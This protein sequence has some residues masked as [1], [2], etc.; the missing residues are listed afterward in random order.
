MVRKGEGYKSRLHIGQEPCLSNQL[1]MQGKWN[2]WWQCG[3]LLTVSPSWKSWRQTEHESLLPEAS[4]LFPPVILI[5]GILSTTSTVNPFEPPVSK[6]LE[7]SSKVAAS[8]GPIWLWT[9]LSIAGPMRSRTSLPLIR[10]TMTSIYTT[11]KQESVFES[12][13]TRKQSSFQE[14]L[15]K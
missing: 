10:L 8:A 13:N 9:A 4:K 6:M 5:L 15:T 14:A 2:M 3:K 12:F 7:R 1:S 11:K